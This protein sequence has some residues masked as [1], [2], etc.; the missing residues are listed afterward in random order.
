MYG[1]FEDPLP[2]PRQRK[3]SGRPVGS[4]RCHANPDDHHKRFEE[5]GHQPAL[6]TE[7]QHGMSYHALAHFGSADGYDPTHCDVG[8]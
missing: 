1:H 8:E 6:E 4:C 7:V 5:I 3:R 2:K